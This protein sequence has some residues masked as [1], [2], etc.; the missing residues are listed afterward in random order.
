MFLDYSLIIV[1]QCLYVSRHCVSSKGQLPFELCRFSFILFLYRPILVGCFI[2]LGNN[3]ISSSINMEHLSIISFLP[4]V[5]HIWGLWPLVVCVCIIGRSIIIR[6][7]FRSICHCYVLFYFVCE[8]FSF[9]L[10]FS[11]CVYFHFLT[12]S[13]G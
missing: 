11:Y 12:L 10:V 9:L 1:F 5:N 4:N 7:K 6:T 13:L 8:F 3:L 2:K